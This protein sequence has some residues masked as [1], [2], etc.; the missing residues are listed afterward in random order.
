MSNPTFLPGRAGGRHFRAGLYAAAGSAAPRPPEVV[1]VPNGLGAVAH[2]AFTG[3][4][5]SL[6]TFARQIPFSQAQRTSTGFGSGV[7]KTSPM[8]GLV[9]GLKHAFRRLWRDLGFTGTVLITLG[10]AVGA[11]TAMFSVVNA[12]LLRTLPYPEPDRLGA[13][14][15]RATGQQS[16]EGRRT[17]DGEQWELLRDSVPSL[18]SAVFAKAVTGVN[19]QA[20]SHVRYVRAGGVSAGFFDVL[21][22]RPLIGRTFA[23]EEDQPHGPK[24]AVLSDSLYRTVFGGQSSAVGQA[25]LLGG[26][27]YTVIGVLP[28]RTTTPLN[29]DIYT[30][31]KPSR[32]NEGR[33]TNYEAIVRLQPGTTWQ[34]AEVEI[35][36]AW[37][38]SARSLATRNGGEQIT[39]YL[40]SLQQGQT[41]ALRPQ[42]LGLMLASGL[43]LLIACANLAGLSL[44]RMLRRRGDFAIRLALGA[45]PGRILLA[46]WFENL[47]IALAGG[48]VAV[49]VGFV[50]LR[51]LLLL[52][53]EGFL[54]VS[55][56]FLDLRV[57][58]FTLLASVLAS[59]LFGMLPA[60]FTGNV[61][62]RSSFVSRTVT[63]TGGVRIRQGLIAGEVALTV[64]L[65][66]AAGLLVRTLIHLQTI[67]PGFNPTNVISAKVSLN[68][69]RYR[70]PA[71]FRS[72]L[73][74]S[75]A[76]IRE[77]PG[78]KRAAVALSLPYER[79]MI[80]RISISDGKEAGRAFQT[81]QVY[82]TP[83]YFETLQI[84]T[85]S[86]RAFAEADGPDAQPVAV[87]NQALARKFFG[88]T[89]PVGRY[90]DKMQIVGVVADTV[91]SSAGQLNRGSAPLTKEETLYVP[92]AQVV[93]A[94]LLSIIH[95]FLQPA[96]IVRIAD[97]AAGVPAQVQRALA[98]TASNLPVS[99]FSSMDDLMTAALTTQR[100]Q[101]ALLGS[102]ALLA[103]VLSAIGIFALVANAVAQRTRE[104]G[105]RMALG[106][107]SRAAI[108]DIGKS[109][110]TASAVGLVIGLSL[111]APVLGAL[112][113]VLFG[114]G[115]YD[116]VTLGAV[117]LTLSLVTVVATA[118][119]A[120]R[121][122]SID[123]ARTLRDE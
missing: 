61:A 19:L 36:R 75:L 80:N 5:S 77:V 72:L 14:Y 83:G 28:E 56:V 111:C 90:L 114:V 24:A 92:A 93:D 35:N 66:A 65:L 45:L 49:A 98:K 54:P 87:V 122:A 109:G 2:S 97:P 118:M 52:L 9:H 34:Q 53:P 3:A 119:P 22:L 59:V 69:A 29:A 101:V 42:V 115:A 31:L 20:G 85:L 76:A 110:A 123:P 39:Y 43:I 121:V 67:P 104:I 116:A 70:D 113:S 108:L 89:D 1:A 95:R 8:D 33:G 57:L 120:L 13:I 91:L 81:N 82:V 68:E 10:L 99:G 18:R 32:E 55:E 41:D 21:G 27:P 23:A 106:S 86:G 71:A 37:A 96:W 74:R 78:V 46:C 44:V 47:L 50:A 64:V 40:V 107:T 88:G 100:I 102:M 105:I 79:A 25:V 63:G 94:R 58:F 117:V 30:A 4:G 48:A 84:A 73:D 26:E 51:G 38:M 12:L 112:R 103:L 6:Q 17:I 62:L 16:F 15:A 60:L 7:L 11:N